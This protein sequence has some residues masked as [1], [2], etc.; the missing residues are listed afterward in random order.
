MYTVEPK[1]NKEL[2][3]WENHLTTHGNDGQYNL[4]ELPKS[5]QCYFAILGKSLQ[6]NPK[7]NE[8]WFEK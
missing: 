3:N 5:N 4:M 6:W 2:R 7:E 8:T 1:Y